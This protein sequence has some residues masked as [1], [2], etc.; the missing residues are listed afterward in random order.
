M[1]TEYEIH[2]VRDSLLGARDTRANEVIAA[3]AREGWELVKVSPMR[4]FATDVGLHLLFRRSTRSAPSPGG[5]P[6]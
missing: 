2:C 5:P 6:G 1:V 4:M 3:R